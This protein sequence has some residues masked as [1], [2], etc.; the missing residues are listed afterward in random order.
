MGKVYDR[1]QTALAA[2]REKTD[3]VP[4]VGL[5][6]GSGLGAFAD[7]S[8]KVVAEVPYRDIP[9]FPVSTAPEIGRAHV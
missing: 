6:L 5:V 2:V 1:L 9:G 4:K 7:T 3:F 8:M